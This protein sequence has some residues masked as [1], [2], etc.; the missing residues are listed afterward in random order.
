MECRLVQVGRSPSGSVRPGPCYPGLADGQGFRRAVRVPASR[1]T[2]VEYRLGVRYQLTDRLAALAGYGRSFVLTSGTGRDGSGFAAERGDGYELGVSS[3]W[4]GVDLALTVFD[5][6]KTDI[7]T[8]DLMDPNFLAPVGRLTTR[9][10]EF[11]GSLRRGDSQVVANYA[12]T[13]AKAD[14]ATFASD[15]VLNVPAHSGS[16]FAIDRF[17]RRSGLSGR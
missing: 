1:D 7:L 13:D 16:L 2:P 8:N 11:D 15:T 4:S 6:V 10:V 12:W 14:D 5:I 17:T 3:A 9:G